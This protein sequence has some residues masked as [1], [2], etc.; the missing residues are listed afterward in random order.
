MATM[1]NVK[2][3]KTEW[4]KGYPTTLRWVR[5]AIFQERN[6]DNKFK[7]AFQWAAF[8]KTQSGLRR[9]YFPEFNGL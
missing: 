3:S 9:K 4:F 5:N 7:N 6:Q 8:I 1:L 2:E